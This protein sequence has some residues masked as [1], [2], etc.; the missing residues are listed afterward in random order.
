M[1]HV[2]RKY[3]GHCMWDG[4]HPSKSE[5]KE[6]GTLHEALEYRSTLTGMVE[7]FE[8]EITNEIIK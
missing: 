2:V 4:T 3:I 1:T 7:I 5:E 8:R 6:F